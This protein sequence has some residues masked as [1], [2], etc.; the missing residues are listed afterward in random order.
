MVVTYY[1]G[2]II[3]NAVKHFFMEAQQ[4][5]EV[6]PPLAAAMSG[7]K[8]GLRGRG[9]GRSRVVSRTRAPRQAGL[10]RRSAPRQDHARLRV[11]PLGG[12]GEFGR[13]MMV[14]EYGNDAVVIDMGVMF[15]TE[16]MPGIDF[17]IP[18]T[19]YLKQ[20]KGKLKGII[21]THGHLDHMGAI[22]YLIKDIG[23]PPVYGTRLTIGMIRDRLEEFHL[24]R[25][26]R[27]VEVHPDDS[28][29]LGVFRLN[30]FRV[31]HN[32]PDSVGVA[33]RTPAGTI[34]HT[35]DWK[36]DHTPQ[37]QRPTEFGKI[38]KLGE[39]GVL[40]L[41]S[42]S[43]RAEVPGYCLSEKDIQANLESLLSKAPGRIIV[44]TFSSLISRI[45][46]VINAA[47]DLNRKV[48]VSGMSMEKVLTTAAKLGYLKM[49]RG[50]LIK[51]DQLRSV[52]D[53]RVVILSTG[54]QGQETSSLVRMSRGE[55]KHVKIQ[56]KD[57]I[58]LS[59]SPIPGNERAVT[60]LMNELYSQGAHVIYNKMFDVHT[61][62][63]GYREELKLMLGLT[64]PRYFMPIHGE[65]YMLVHHA[66]LARS[67]GWDDRSLFVIDNGTVIE[68]DA[69]GAARV[70]HEKIKVDNVMVDGLGVGDIEHVVLRE[71]KV[72]AQDGM[73]VVIVAVDKDGKLVG[74]PDIISRGFVYV[75][76][77]ERLIAEVRGA[78]RKIVDGYTCADVEN[79]SPVRNRIRD[80]VGLL[81]FKRTEKRPMVLP[82]VIKV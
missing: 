11:I 74:S 10:I 65:R 5:N 75:K 43:T 9:Y 19:S 2:R 79:W 80:D 72:L 3:C 64:R 42:D 33:V 44:A 35:G 13:N 50:T 59:S 67:M 27:C 21:I 4:V 41:C 60:N 46:Q 16:S 40:L 29:Q 37:D 31:N 39:E 30:F 23:S 34:I 7:L 15:P 1:Q 22:P 8:A 18:D 51:V 6:A 14:I 24:D 73:V 32:I 78:V 52:P 82:V 49:P 61:S 70:G 76:T 48:A 62:G 77:S 54:S 53:E 20:H 58:I 68:F 25:H 47:V 56:P 71:R 28:L 63:H 36:F 12:I 38:A 69:T 81:L 45:Q 55:H 17:V 66:E 57:T 26:V